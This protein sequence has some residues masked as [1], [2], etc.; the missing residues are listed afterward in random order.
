M[1][2]PF[3]F[4]NKQ[5]WGK[6]DDSRIQFTSFVKHGTTQNDPEPFKTIQNHQEL[7]RTNR[8]KSLKTTKNHPKTS[9]MNRVHLESTI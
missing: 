3:F 6:I 1:R 8:N 7:R 5:E 9:K 2:A 4:L